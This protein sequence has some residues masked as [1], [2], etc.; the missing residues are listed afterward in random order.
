MQF[1]PFD[2]TL[3]DRNDDDGIPNSLVVLWYR[4]CFPLATVF[5]YLV[6]IKSY[7]L[8]RGE[9]LRSTYEVDL[10]P[11][12]GLIFLIVYLSCCIDVFA[13]LLKVMNCK[14][15][16]PMDPDSHPYAYCDVMQDRAVWMEDTSV[17]CWEGP[18]LVSTILAVFGLCV[19][20][21]VM[22][23]IVAI[24]R[25]GKKKQQLRKPAF[26]LNYGFLYLGYRTDGLALHWESVITIRRMLLAAVGVFAQSR[27]TSNV[28]IGL[29]AI[30]IFTAIALHEIV[31]PFE[32]ESI[33]DVF[34]VYA[35]S[36][37][38]SI[39]A[40]DLANRWLAFNQYVSLN[41][42]EG[43]SLFM[44]LAL[45]L[46]AASI[47]D[48]HGNEIEANLLIFVSFFLN[49]IFSVFMVYRLW[50]AYHK[51]LDTLADEKSISFKGVD[52][53]EVDRDTF[54]LKKIWCIAT[55]SHE[56]VETQNTDDGAV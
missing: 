29:L 1:L 40:H 26:M 17:T 21:G 37:L 49:A 6:I 4:V 22:G 7:T 55:H 30:I 31:Q 36:I 38:R 33:K 20:F 15:L 41:S 25:R 27:E 10:I 48:R 14:R 11:P 35:G 3:S 13:D 28:R 39:G 52:D 46:T 43:A 53:M 44:S 9:R 45:F 23:F 2:C 50:C 51:Y 32:P 54:L 42:L 24:L 5:C 12:S 18:H 19:C 47:K 56:N 16:S 34:P 8:L